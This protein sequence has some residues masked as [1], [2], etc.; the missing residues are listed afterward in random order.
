MQCPDTV[1]FHPSRQAR[2]LWQAAERDRQGFRGVRIAQGCSNIKGNRRFTGRAAITVK[3]VVTALAIDGVVAA[4]AIQNIVILG[5]FDL[6]VIGQE[7]RSERDIGNIKR[8]L[9]CYR[10]HIQRHR[11]AIDTAVTIGNH[12]GEG[13]G[14]AKVLI[15]DIS[16]RAAGVHNDK[17]MFR[18]AIRIKGERQFVLID[19]GG[20]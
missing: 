2:A 5:A 16:V 3:D 10:R 7:L 15:R 13:V 18:R 12:V 14:T 8:R 20:R 11:G 17:A 6:V 4:T 1:G 9:V 19:I